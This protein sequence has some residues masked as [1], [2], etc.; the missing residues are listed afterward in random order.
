MLVVGIVTWPYVDPIATWY[1]VKLRWEDSN[2]I[3]RPLISLHWLPMHPSD[4]NCAKLPKYKQVASQYAMWYLASWLRNPL[5]G[6]SLK[7]NDHPTFRIYVYQ[8]PVPKKLVKKLPSS[9]SIKSSS[10]HSRPL[11]HITPRWTDGRQF[12]RVFIPATCI[13][14]GVWQVLENDRMSSR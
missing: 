3:S 2:T 1:S 9:W 5:L 4:D 13:M 14:L 12:I 10:P 7:P 11:P 8:G 6:I